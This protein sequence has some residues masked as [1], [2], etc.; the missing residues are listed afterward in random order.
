MEVQTGKFY[1]NREGR[2][3]KVLEQ[4]QVFM[5]SQTAQFNADLSAGKVDPLDDDLAR[6]DQ[7]MCFLCWPGGDEFEYYVL[8]TGQAC[9]AYKLLSGEQLRWAYPT[10]EFEVVDDAD[11]VSEVPASA[12]LARKYTEKDYE[13]DQHIVV[14]LKVRARNYDDVQSKLPEE[15]L[16]AE[17]LRPLFT[18]S[19]VE[20]VEVTYDY[21][22]GGIVSPEDEDEEEGEDE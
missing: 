4:T 11:L 12:A 1:R 16:V 17:A 15:S 22:G 3:V 10:P 5:R 14:S 6:G 8:P 7:T 20:V 9:V 13:L 2:V 21:E 18:S 19:V